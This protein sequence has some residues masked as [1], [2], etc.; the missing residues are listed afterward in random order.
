MKRP[1]RILSLVAALALAPAAAPAQ[2]GDCRY[3]CGRIYLDCLDAAGCFLNGGC[4]DGS[5]CQSNRCA[6]GQLCGATPPGCDAGCFAALATCRAG[7]GESY[8]RVVR[9]ALPFLNLDDDA[10]KRLLE[11]IEA[12]DRQLEE[13]LGGGAALAGRHLTEFRK[14]AWELAAEAGQAEQGISATDALALEKVVLE[15]ELALRRDGLRQC[16]SDLL[17]P[18]VILLDPGLFQSVKRCGDFFTESG[19]ASGAV[20]ACKTIPPELELRLANEAVADAD[21]RASDRCPRDCSA[22][23]VQSLSNRRDCRDAQV[24]V[25]VTRRYRCSPAG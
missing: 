15:A 5:V 11:P 14:L 22:R 20:K 13:V 3:D 4:R 9:D 17:E 10:A 1:G 23:F 8:L 19:G 21:Q 12:A 7:C 24:S 16:V 25:S 2:T 18:D 6:D